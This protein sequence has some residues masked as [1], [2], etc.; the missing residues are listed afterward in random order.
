MQR[1]IKRTKK[2]V[3][4]Q[5]EI[6][7]FSSYSHNNNSAQFSC[8]S[9]SSSYAS[10][11]PT[12]KIRNPLSSNFYQEPSENKQQSPSSSV[13]RCRTNTT[14][15]EN[16]DFQSA[17]TVTTTKKSKSNYTPVFIIISRMESLGPSGY[18]IKGRI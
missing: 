7:P 14:K 16:N 8:P 1:K 15:N 10:A 6:Y 5:P 4:I 11:A 12:H 17:W 9:S 2:R 18:S 3:A 13:S